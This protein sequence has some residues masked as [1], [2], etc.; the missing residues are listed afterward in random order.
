[1]HAATSIRRSGGCSLEQGPAHLRATV[2]PGLA[3]EVQECYR[4]LVHE[5][6]QRHFT[7]ALILGRARVD[8]FNHLA[9]RDALRSMSVAGV[10]ADLRIALV[11]E[12]PDL[13]AIYDAAVVEAG[14]CG[15][16]V[17]RFSTP[18]EAERWLTSPSASES[19]PSAGASP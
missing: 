4:A 12:T 11:A 2:G 7:R 19:P 15:I 8:A 3:D 16:E 14:R 17:R 1:M 9:L 18:A 6:L 5:C 13:I 10:P